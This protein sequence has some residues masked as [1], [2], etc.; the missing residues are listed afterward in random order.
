MKL[1]LIQFSRKLT[2]LLLLLSGQRDQTLHMLDIR[3][4]TV[5]DSWVSFRNGDALKSSRPGVHLS[6]LVFAA[7]P[8]DRRLCV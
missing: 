1:S 2:L 5:L 3:N 8:P 6:E 7:Y 4:M